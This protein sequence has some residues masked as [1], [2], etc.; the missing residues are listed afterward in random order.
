MR[1]SGIHEL[2]R[3]QVLILARSLMVDMNLLAVFRGFRELCD[4]LLRNLEPIGHTNFL[5]HV[6]FEQYRAFDWQWW[7]KLF[8]VA[9]LFELRWISLRR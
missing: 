5:A 7:H 8:P 9:A 2:W 6:F 3:C 4:A 1:E